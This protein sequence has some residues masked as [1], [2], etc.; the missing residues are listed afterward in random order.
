MSSPSSE[1]LCVDTGPSESGVGLEGQGG[2]GKTRWQASAAVQV[3]GEGVQAGAPAGLAD[4]HFK[5]CPAMELIQN[6]GHW[7]WLLEDRKGLPR[8]ASRKLK[9]PRCLSLG[10]GSLER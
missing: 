8:V 3:R 7:S 9:G 10:T 1:N 2:C 6:H 4:S 5:L